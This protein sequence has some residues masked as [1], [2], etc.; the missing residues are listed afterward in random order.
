M[1]QIVWRVSQMWAL[2]ED[3]LAWITKGVKRLTTE[4]AVVSEFGRNVREGREG[5]VCIAGGARQ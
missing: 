2:N 5:A 1:E 3:L 4:T